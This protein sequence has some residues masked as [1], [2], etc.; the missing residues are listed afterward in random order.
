M[1][2]CIED[3]HKTPPCSYFNEWV[4][5]C[6][7]GARP[8]G[9][10]T[11]LLPSESQ[12]RSAPRDSQCPRVSMAPPHLIYNETMSSQ[13]ALKILNFPFIVY[14]LFFNVF[15]FT[16]IVLLLPL[17]RC[18]HW[19]SCLRHYVVLPPGYAQAD[20]RVKHRVATPCFRINHQKHSQTA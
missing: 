17:H 4:L 10:A 7:S 16:E 2:M 12:W 9:G 6:R 8:Q 18:I 13:G 20:G 19:V 5:L 14:Y 3:S 1:K 11:T 15:L